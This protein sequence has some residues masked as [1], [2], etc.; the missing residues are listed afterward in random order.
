LIGAAIA[1]SAYAAI[2][3]PDTVISTP[4]GERALASEQAERSRP[5]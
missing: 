5:K 1:A 2:R 3:M 4:Q